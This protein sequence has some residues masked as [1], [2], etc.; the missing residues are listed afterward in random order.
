MPERMLFFIGNLNLQVGEDGITIED[1][2]DIKVTPEKFLRIPQLEMQAVGHFF[3][4]ELFRLWRCVL[5]RISKIFKC[6][7][8]LPQFGL[9]LFGLPWCCLHVDLEIVHE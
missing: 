4:F 3:L 7:R 9:V 1:F 6:N 5:G 8:A 2:S